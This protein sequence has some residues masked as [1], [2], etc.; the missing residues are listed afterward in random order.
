MKKK[1]RKKT[2]AQLLYIFFK[3]SLALC[4]LFHSLPAINQSVFSILIFLRPCC[5]K[6]FSAKKKKCRGAA[7]IISK[8]KKKLE[9]WRSSGHEEKIKLN[10]TS[11]MRQKCTEQIKTPRLLT[12]KTKPRHLNA[13]SPRAAGRPASTR[14]RTPHPLLPI[15]EMSSLPGSVRIY[16]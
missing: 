3:I 8:Q 6:V 4:K 9:F 2:Q 7:V 11:A 14:R 1:V 5:V 16:M 12:R 13:R 15:L 10:P